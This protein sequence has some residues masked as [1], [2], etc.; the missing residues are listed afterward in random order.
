MSH[1]QL[2]NQTIVRKSPVVIVKTFMVLQMTAVAVFFLAGVVA[3]YGELYANLPFSNSLSFH[4]AEI[5]GIFLLET[6]LVF[7]IFFSWH[8]EYY[9]IQRDKITHAKGLIFRKRSTIPISAIYSINY[10]QGP[11]GRLTKYGHI[12]LKE[13]SSGKVTVLDNIPEPEQYVELIA[14][15]K[16]SLQKIR[17][18]PDQSLIKIIA[19][20]EHERLE[21]KT[22]FRWDMRQNKVNKNLERA[23]MK[24][25][26]AFLNSDGGQLVIG[27]DDTSKVIGLENDFKS[28]SKPNSD[29]F[30]NHF[31][32]IFHT[33][34]GPEFRQFIELSFHDVDNQNC[35][36]VRVQPANRPTYLRLDNGEEFYIRTGNGTT[37]LKL[38]EAAAYADSHWRGKLL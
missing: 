1:W 30:Q 7:Y 12:E 23:V 14:N 9:N 2:N 22:S 6:I 32:N 18:Y 29:G 26:V 13:S 21:F 27:V 19:E 36:L 17:N 33:M 20:G 35:C 31:T 38:S 4:I 25:I 28:L 15:L 3:D 37:G 5:I 11:L 10:R 8:K 34:V 16:N 24:T